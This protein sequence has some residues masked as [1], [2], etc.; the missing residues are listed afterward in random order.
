MKDVEKKP[1]DKKGNAYTVST[2]L[3]D[4]TKYYRYNEFVVANEDRTIILDDRIA[5]LSSRGKEYMADFRRE[6][7]GRKVLAIEHT[8][9]GNKHV[10][11]LILEGG[12]KN[13]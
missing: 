2:W 11:T 1:L 5:Y 6:V 10:I 7:K 8:Y 4:N 9:P 12:K 3:K 13:V